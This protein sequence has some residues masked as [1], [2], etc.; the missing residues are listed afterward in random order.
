MKNYTLFCVSV[1]SEGTYDYR[2]LKSMTPMS[3]RK[4]RGLVKK[5]QKA[6][7]DNLVAKNRSLV[8]GHDLWEK[9]IKRLKKEF[10]FTAANPIEYFIY[11]FNFWDDKEEK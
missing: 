5:V 11:E 6:E 4:F 2:I 9:V 1:G 7:W 3:A 10:N 8:T